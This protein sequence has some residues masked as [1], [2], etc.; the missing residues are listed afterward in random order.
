M[1][2]MGIRERLRQFLRL[3]LQ[4]RYVSP[5]DKFLM[6]FD[7]ANPKPSLS[8]EAEISKFRRIFKLRDQKS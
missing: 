7:S 4:R 3:D 1:A 6:E 5:I 8:Q 2:A